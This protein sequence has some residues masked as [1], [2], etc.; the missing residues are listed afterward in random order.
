MFGCSLLSRRLNEGST[1][2]GITVRAEAGQPERLNWKDD[3]LGRALNAGN[4]TF[5]LGTNL[6][7]YSW[8]AYPNH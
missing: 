6:R 8:Q 3:N 1:L 4:K 7:A 5:E 2:F